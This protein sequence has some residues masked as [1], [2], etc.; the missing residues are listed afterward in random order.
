MSDATEM[1]NP[2]TGRPFVW[3]EYCSFDD[4]ILIFG[5]EDTSIVQIG[6]IAEK[7]DVK[8]YDCET[9]EDL[10][11]VPAFMALVNPLR[12]A[13]AEA[14]I[15]TALWQEY[16]TNEFKVIFSET[17]G[18]YWP[19]PLP[20]C[21]KVELDMFA[22]Q[23]KL[24]LNVL[25]QKTSVSRPA[26][27]AKQYEERIVRILTI[28][29]RL[30]KG[31]VKTRELAKEFK[32]SVRTVQRDIRILEWTGELISYDEREKAFFLLGNDGFGEEKQKEGIIDE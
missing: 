22:D 21:V 11:A 20:S 29:K 31:P 19:Q 2:M 15:L 28:L 17:P 27:L 10:L 3:N 1:M 26:R 5:L 13:H 4:T 12:I 8:V 23:E 25:K 14:A 9:I 7:L 18:S 24:R 16:D 6:D 30:Q 32:V